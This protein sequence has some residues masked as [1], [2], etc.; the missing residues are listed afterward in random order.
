MEKER[1]KAD[2]KDDS[3]E[4]SFVN[5]KACVDL[6]QLFILCMP[7]CSSIQLQEYLPEVL[8]SGKAVKKEATRADSKPKSEK[9][10]EDSW[11]FTLK[12]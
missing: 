10:S 4:V 1:M 2:C 5:C 12:R 6:S 7:L 8:L 9:S 11:D 3:T